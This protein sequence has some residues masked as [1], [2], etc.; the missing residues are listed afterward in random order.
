MNRRVVFSVSVLAS[1]I[2]L[3]GFQEKN[4]VSWLVNVNSTWKS[5]HYLNDTA[6]ETGKSQSASRRLAH[7]LAKAVRL[8][9]KGIFLFIFPVFLWFSF[10][11]LRETSLSSLVF[12]FS[13]RLFCPIKDSIFWR[14]RTDVFFCF[15]RTSRCSTSISFNIQE[16]SNI[17]KL[18]FCV[19]LWFPSKYFWELWAIC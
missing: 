2:N 11:S 5:H 13:S 3:K 18:D 9:S 10:W 12:L 4:T 17:Y 6:R 16:Y 8:F 1:G 15:V 7:V 19:A 14:W